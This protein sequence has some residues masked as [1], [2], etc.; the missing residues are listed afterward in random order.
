MAYVES[1][2]MNYTCFTKKRFWLQQTAIGRIYHQMTLGHRRK[3]CNAKSKVP[4]GRPR[5]RWTDGVAKDANILLN[6]RRWT[7]VAKNRIS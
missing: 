4:I 2:T 6:V 5:D 7:N 1:D 3:Y